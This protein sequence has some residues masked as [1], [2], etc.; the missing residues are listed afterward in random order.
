MI[1]NR[2]YRTAVLLILTAFIACN[3]P[4]NQTSNQKNGI[5]S[6]SI[7]SLKLIE[8]PVSSTDISFGLLNVEK[9]L[10]IDLDDE[11]A[12]SLM[13]QSKKNY[14][15]IN[16]KS[17]ELR[18]NKIQEEGKD[19]TGRQTISEFDNV[20]GGLFYLPEKVKTDNE[21]VFLYKDD[22]LKNRKILAVKKV[23]EDAIDNPV[24]STLKKLF[25]NSITSSKLIATTTQN[26]SIFLS[27]LALKADTIN[28]LLTA[29]SSTGK[30]FI[31]EYKE[32]YNEMST[33]RVDDGGEFPMEYFSILNAFNTN[34]KIELITSFPGPEG[35]NFALEIPDSKNRYYTA[36]EIAAYWSPL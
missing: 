27:Q 18:F 29:K 16:N 3:S 35:G 2:L 1:I 22:F 17:Y 15:L 19:Y 5:D 7:T 4:A 32:E 25:N 33:W 30:L 13:S 14:A 10:I 36:K 9:S 20:P 24:N 34:G 8:D 31:K 26:D 12:D 21:Y 11:E 6:T 28:V 23:F